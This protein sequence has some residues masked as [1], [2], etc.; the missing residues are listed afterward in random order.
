MLKV[1]E[2]KNHIIFLYLVL[3][4]AV[5]YVHRLVAQHFVDNPNNY[6]EVDH[7]SNCK[8]QNEASNLRWVSRTH[9]LERINA[10]PIISL[11]LITGE[12]IFFKT[13]LDAANYFN[14]G[15]NTVDTNSK[16]KNRKRRMNSVLDYIRFYD[17]EVND[18]EAIIDNHYN[19]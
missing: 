9:N 6:T 15:S 16:N 18:I 12:K 10:T 11:N 3:I 4:I 2:R 19:N 8:T 7:F 13:Q 14:V 5:I 1:L 17:A